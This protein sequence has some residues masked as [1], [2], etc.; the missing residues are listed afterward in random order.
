[1]KQTI[2]ILNQEEV[3]GLFSL[4]FGLICYLVI[5]VIGFIFGYSGSAKTGS[6]I[7]P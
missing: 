4:L 3:Y 2:K 1:M 6:I 5:F 7:A